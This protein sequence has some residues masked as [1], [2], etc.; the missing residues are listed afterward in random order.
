MFYRVVTR[1][2][3]IPIRLFVDVENV[4]PQKSPSLRILAISSME[5]RI[6]YQMESICGTYLVCSI[7]LK[8]LAVAF[9]V[10]VN[11]LQSDRVPT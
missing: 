1:L 8:G 10:V 6:T 3:S 2:T 5:Q 11:L 9:D 4:C 7:M